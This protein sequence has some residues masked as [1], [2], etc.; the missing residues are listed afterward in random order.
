MGRARLKLTV[1]PALKAE[2]KKR[3]KAANEVRQRQRLQAI[4]L[5]TTGQH[6]YRDIGQIVG[7]SPSTFSLWLN[8]FLSGGIAEL[9][10]RETPPGSPSPL[11]AA[12][13]QAEL[14]KQS[15]HES[16]RTADIAPNSA[17]DSPESGSSRDTT[18]PEQFTEGR[19][20]PLAAKALIEIIHHNPKAYG[21]NRTNW[22]LESLAYAFE[23]QFGQKPARSTVGRLLKQAG[24]RWKKSR[25]VLTST[26][27]NYKEKVELLLKTLKS[28]KADE[29]LFFIDEMGPLAVRR[30]G[31]R[32]YT[33]K[34]EA[35]T[36]PKN[37]RAKGSIALYGALSAKTNQVVW[38]Y[39]KSKDS[40]GMIE[41]AEVLYN[42]QHDKS[43]IFLT[44]DAAS[45]H[46]SEELVQWTDAFN[47]WN[48]ADGT[49]PHI[50]FIPLPSNSQ[51]LDVIEAVFSGMKRAVIHNSDYQSPAKMKAAISMHFRERNDY[52]RDNPKRVGKKMWEIDFFEDHNN[53][54][55]GN[56]REW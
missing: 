23:K 36:H 35:P 55:W 11:G 52:F 13:L 15:R 14:C 12:V 41:L 49:G 32:C 51:F 24:L 40:A 48:S 26:D 43:K 30:H 8:K 34:G 31:G 20:L 39:G 53:I 22:T 29:D 17:A 28:L 1:D 27:P 37:Q 7:C 38:F 42:Q 54:R 19:K 3:F 4:L 47:T 10:R 18:C 25:Q 21:I 56:Y 50:E 45:W 16:S 9:L 33:P 46:R 44:W 2:L 5:A 6:G